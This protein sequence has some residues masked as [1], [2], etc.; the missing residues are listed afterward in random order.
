[1]PQPV[2]IRI[3]R[4]KKNQVVLDHPD[5]ADEHLELFADREGNVF[6]T[7]LG[8]TQG[9]LLNGQPLKGYVLL[10]ENDQV[11]LGKSVR[12]NWKKYRL[13]PTTD[14]P[15]RPKSQPKPIQIQS[16]PR[17]RMQ[18]KSPAANMEV[19]TKSLYIIYGIILLLI[20]IISLIN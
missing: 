15:V 13:T 14:D 5:I 17:P 20:L 18:K 1:M 12:F 8:S 11:V 6:V 4:S 10:N 3:G 16:D 19:E 9:T 2:N 7:D